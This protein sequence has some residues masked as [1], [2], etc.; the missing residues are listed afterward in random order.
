M[1][2]YWFEYFDI[3]R[4]TIKDSHIKGKRTPKISE[5]ILRKLYWKDNL[6]LKDIGIIYGLSEF[7]ILK[8][9]QYYG[10]PCRSRSE[11]TLKRD[12]EDPDLKE[13]QCEIQQ[14]KW[15]LMSDEDRLIHAKHVSA[16]RQG[17]PYEEW[18][19]FVSDGWRDTV[20]YAEWTAAVIKRDNNTCR[21][22]NTKVGI[23]HRHHIYP[24]RNYPELKYDVENGITLCP[25]CHY[26]TFGCEEEWADIFI[27]LIN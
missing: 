14:N 13:R 12:M 17:I 23:K 3:P 20:E 4:R 26:K 7:T 15:D 22:C 24:V 18:E 9:F 11:A 19:D 25:G 27:M 2:Y 21:L 1:M 16:G 8:Y 6:I 10:I 5:I